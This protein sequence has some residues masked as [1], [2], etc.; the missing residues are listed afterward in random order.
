METG[1]Y[2]TGPSEGAEGASANR[3]RVKILAD[4]CVPDETQV[5]VEVGVCESVTH[6]HDFAPGY[7]RIPL[8]ISRVLEPERSETHD[9]PRLASYV[10]EISV[11]PLAAREARRALDAPAHFRLAVPPFQAKGVAFAQTVLRAG[12]TAVGSHA[13]MR[14]KR[15]MSWASDSAFVRVS[16]S[17]TMYSQRPMCSASSAS[18]RQPDRIRPIA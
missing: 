7:L 15:Q 14:K 16:P 10:P 18:T 2:V 1:R 17:G 12:R 9:C 4:Y 13:A 3:P 5:D 11:S 8:L 6:P